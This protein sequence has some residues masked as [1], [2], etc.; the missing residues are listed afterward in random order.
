MPSGPAWQRRPPRGRGTRRTGGRLLLDAS[1]RLQRPPL[2]QPFRCQLL[3]LT[4]P[5][6]SSLFA[7]FLPSLCSLL[8][9]WLPPFSLFFASLL[10]LLL[11]VFCLLFTPFLPPFCPSFSPLKA[12]FP[13]FCSSFSHSCSFLA[14]SPPYFV[15]LHPS[16]S[17]S[18]PFILPF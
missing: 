1:P 14:L 16:L 6:F 15:P 17:V 18:A 3:P 2:P 9:S 8:A 11:L 7:L 4:F 13:L 12:P 10:P 5:P